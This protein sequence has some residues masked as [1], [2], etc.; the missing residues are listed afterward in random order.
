MSCGP[1]VY[2]E[3][4]DH[5]QL[6]S[7]VSLVFSTFYIN[8]LPEQTLFCCLMYRKLVLSGIPFQKMSSAPSLSIF[9]L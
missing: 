4:Q 2:D 9:K 1:S 5:I 8:P 6:N 7:V 3:F